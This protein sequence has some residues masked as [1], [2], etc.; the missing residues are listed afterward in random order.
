M[1][2]TIKGSTVVWSVNS[3]ACS[4]LIAGIEQSFSR[5]ASSSQKEIIGDGGDCIT[6]IYTNAKADLSIE[7]V[8]TSRAVFPAIGTVC[9]VSGGTDMVG[10]HSGKYILTGGSQESS[11]DGE[12]RYSFDLEQYTATNLGAP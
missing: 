4:G 10:G 3:L 8:P 11:S 5:S 7:V 6:K 2:A 12:A 1:A 9:T